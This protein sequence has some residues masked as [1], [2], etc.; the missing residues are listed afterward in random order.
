VIF[1]ALGIKIDWITWRLKN[2]RYN[3]SREREETYGY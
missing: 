2:K 1:E 3:S